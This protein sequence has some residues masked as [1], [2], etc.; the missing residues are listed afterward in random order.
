MEEADDREER[1]TTRL[2]PR[3][4]P[5]LWI[6]PKGGQ[7]TPS[8]ADG[9]TPALNSNGHKVEKNRIEREGKCADSIFVSLLSAYRLTYF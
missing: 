7:E 6:F 9:R 1:L 2:V 8:A 5:R 4:R 3:H